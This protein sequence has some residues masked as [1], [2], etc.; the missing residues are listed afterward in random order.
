MKNVFLLSILVLNFGVCT[1]QGHKIF[2]QFPAEVVTL[3]QGYISEQE[4]QD[5]YYYGSID[6]IRDTVDFL[7]YKIRIDPGIDTFPIFQMVESSN[8]FVQLDSQRLP[9][10]FP[11]DVYFSNFTYT[12]LSDNRYL[13][14]SI[15]GS[16]GLYI[17]FIGRARSENEAADSRILEIDY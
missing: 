11:S 8:R 2:Y 14:T 16:G 15:G 5:I 12:K 13:V 4:E 1:A 9:L 17:R 3:I 6:V 7:L 10:I